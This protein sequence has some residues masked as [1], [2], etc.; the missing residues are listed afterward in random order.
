MGVEDSFGTKQKSKSAAPQ[1]DDWICFCIQH[2]F[3]QCQIE[4]R[5]ES[6]WIF[7]VK[8]DLDSNELWSFFL[9]FS[10]SRLKVDGCFENWMMKQISTTTQI[11]E[12]TVL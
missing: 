7:V 1:G 9:F 3:S 4:K 8:S 5:Y 12:P 11:P 2:V 10:T 6:S